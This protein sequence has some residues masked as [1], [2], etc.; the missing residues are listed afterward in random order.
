MK[1]D[2]QAK[3]SY[4]ALLILP[5]VAGVLWVN[6]IL[7]ITP[8]FEGSELFFYDP[9]YA[10]LLNG[11]TIL[12]GKPPY[13]IDHPGTPLQVLIAVVVFVKWLFTG[14]NPDVVTDAINNPENYI[15][16][17][18]TVLLF[19]NVWAMYFLGKKVY[20]VSG[21]MLSAMI[22]QLT[23]LVFYR[24]ATKAVFMAPEALLIF[25]SMVLIGLFA[26]VFF[27][28][29]K[30]QDVINDISP[31]IV[32][33]VCGFGVAVKITFIPMLA[34]LFL[35]GSRKRIITG[36][37]FTF[38]AFFFFV[39]PALPNAGRFIEWII[40]ILMGSGMYGGG[41]EKFIDTRSIPIKIYN[42]SVAFSFFYLTAFL[43]AI[44]VIAST[45][46]NLKKTNVNYK[47]PLTFLIIMLVHT[48][49]VIKHYGLHYMA[50]VLPIGVIGFVWFVRSGLIAS[51][52]KKTET[53]ILAVAMFLLVI[54]SIELIKFDVQVIMSDR[55]GSRASINAITPELAKYPD[56]LI[57]GTYRC[58]LPECALLF[59]SQF[60]INI[61]WRL[62]SILKNY[63][64]FEYRGKELYIPNEGF[65]N[66]SI[67][68]QYLNDGREVLLVSRKYRS[69]NLF[70]LEPLVITEGQSL[71]R[72]TGLKQ[73]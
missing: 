19:L 62:R 65:G 5:L 39:L 66:I 16:Y 36:L 56:A 55:M 18:S 41:T 33:V 13:H 67:L 35:L 6:I 7:L 12:D 38:L 8:I 29:D 10:Y 24:Y 40:S 48:L 11:L 57:L 2:I 9:A 54:S 14:T 64:W 46:K 22:C 69:L 50:S 27:A 32:G 15:F 42:L 60:S 21:S 47:I 52:D 30:K 37:I 31:A 59:N 25:S 71:Y 44:A 58:T 1:T 23:P 28:F 68:N 4:L 61:N 49:A 34:L 63:V 53:R 3:Y 17:V 73:N 43:M 72:V 51:F 26:P 20:W 70:D 45:F